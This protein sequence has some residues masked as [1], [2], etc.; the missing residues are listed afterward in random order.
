MSGYRV[1]KVITPPIVSVSSAPRPVARVFSW[2]VPLRRSELPRHVVLAGVGRVRV[3]IHNIFVAPTAP[4]SLLPVVVVGSGRLGRN[5]VRP[6]FGA[7]IG[8]GARQAL[9]SAGSLRVREVYA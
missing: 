5:T 7:G 9:S 6:R 3:T 8:F 2:Q 1:K 4:C